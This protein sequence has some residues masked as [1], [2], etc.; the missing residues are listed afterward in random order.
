MSYLLFTVFLWIHIIKMLGSKEHEQEIKIVSKWWHF[1]V[2]CSSIED[3]D[4]MCNVSMW[5]SAQ[6]PTL[7]IALLMLQSRVIVGVLC[8][9]LC[10][11]AL[12]KAQFSG[13]IDIVKGSSLSLA[14]IIL[15]WLSKTFQNLS[16]IAFLQTRREQILGKELD[17]IQWI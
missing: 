4:R 12:Q 1:Q 7:I 6:S 9:C 10:P 11:D 14:G 5:L 15:G 17:I 13:N 16:K 3:W 8:C 2:A